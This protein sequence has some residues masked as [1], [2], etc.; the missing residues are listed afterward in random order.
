LSQEIQ[1][2]ERSQTKGSGRDTGD[3]KR[4]HDLKV[5]ERRLPAKHLPKSKK[6]KVDI[7]EKYRCILRMPHLTKGEIDEMRKYIC[8]LARTVCEHVWGKKVY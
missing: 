8:L 4:Q 1:E 7:Y 6:R 5:G 3:Q 2:G